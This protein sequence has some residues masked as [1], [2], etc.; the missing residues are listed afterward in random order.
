MIPGSTPKTNPVARTSITALVN[1]IF[2]VYQ[3]IRRYARC[4]GDYIS[5]M[6]R[7]CFFVRGRGGFNLFLPSCE[8]E[9]DQH[10]LLHLKKWPV[11]Y[12]CVPQSFDQS[13]NK[14][15]TDSKYEERRPSLFWQSKL[16]FRYSNYSQG[17][18]CWDPVLIQNGTHP[19]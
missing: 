4:A 6:S 7:H 18:C 11:G 19:S 3:G 9:R 1:D 8:H 16:C 14:P 15:G 2:P 12:K 5:A 17:R 13:V 10:T